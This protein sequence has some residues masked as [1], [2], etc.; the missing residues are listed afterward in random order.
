MDF[1]INYALDM[2]AH[3]LLT[4]RNSDNKFWQ[5]SICIIYT[6]WDA[7]SFTSSIPHM[8]NRLLYI[9]P[10]FTYQNSAFCPQ[11]VSVFR[12]VLTINSDCFPKQH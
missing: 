4:K 1:H 9:P 11:S 3:T 2:N 5:E 7:W 8:F 12:M 6:T 10:A